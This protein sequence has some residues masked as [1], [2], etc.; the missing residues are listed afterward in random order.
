[1]QPLVGAI[2]VEWRRRI[3]A[4]ERGREILA[5][6]SSQ[7]SG[8]QPQFPVYL[9]RNDGSRRAFSVFSTDFQSHFPGKDA[10]IQ[11]I[12]RAAP[13]LCARKGRKLAHRHPNSRT[14]ADRTDAADRKGF[15]M[16]ITVKILLSAAVLFSALGATAFSLN[17]RQQ[18]PKSLTEEDARPA[19]SVGPT[20]DDPLKADVSWV[21]WPSLTDF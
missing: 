11:A 16:A 14:H 10:E 15:V 5:G 2:D 1:L 13:S 17:L 6:D 8:S 7:R 12:P 4:P 9:P 18:L 3:D 19:A 21:R 20:K